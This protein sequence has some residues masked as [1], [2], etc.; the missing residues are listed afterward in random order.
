MGNLETPPIDINNSPGVVSC[1]HAGANAGAACICT[2]MNSPQNL[3]KYS[4]NDSS[5]RFTCGILAS[6]IFAQKLIRQDV[7]LVCTSRADIITF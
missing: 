3:A 5:K 4:E 7:F 2:E 6:A 1:I